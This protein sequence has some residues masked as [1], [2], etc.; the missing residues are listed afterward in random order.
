MKIGEFS[1]KFQLPQHTVRY[2][3]ELGI[4]V[5][6]V[7][8]RQYYFNE[9]CEADMRLIEK[10]KSAGFTLKEIHQILS[11]RRLSNFTSPE[12]GR[13]LQRCMQNR[14]EELEDQRKV[15]EAKRLRI[16]RRMEELGTSSAPEP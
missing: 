11:L 9:D 13:Q 10:S 7:K 6:E 4:L 12:D 1:R 5:P 8:N 16:E 15:W 2:Y 3:A 14:L